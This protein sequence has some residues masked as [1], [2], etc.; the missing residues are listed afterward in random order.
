MNSKYIKFIIFIVCLLVLG[1][2]FAP[3]LV[4]VKDFFYKA[5]KPFS[6][7]IS[8]VTNNVGGIIS[9]IKNIRNLQRE[10]YD[11]K[12]ENDEL[13]AKIASLNEVS[14]ENE[15]LK[16]E[17]GFVGASPEKEL[18]PARVINKSP[19]SFFQNI[20]IDK[21]ASSGVEK[22]KAVLSEGYLVGIVQDVGA[23]YS[24]VTLI[25]DSRSLVAVVLQD[26]RGTG[27]LRGG[28]KGLIMEDIPLDIKTKNG[29]M[30]V[31]SGIGDGLPSG[32][33][34]GQVENIISSTSEIFQRATIKSPIEFGNIEFAFV[35]K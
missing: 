23:D 32:I 21:G 10:N 17:L 7:K 4:L 5:V 3:E 28:L 14:H 16:K 12:K 33:A 8:A 9:D 34:V 30:V 35:V 25:T 15:V 6:Q 19:A 29:E 11:Y 27:L 26:S 31:T 18:I 22:G 2:F 1:L 13:K 24:D 20:R